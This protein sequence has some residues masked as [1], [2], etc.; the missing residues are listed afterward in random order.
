MQAAAAAVQQG[1][2]ECMGTASTN[3]CEL[4]DILRLKS[5]KHIR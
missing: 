2:S 3:E 1:I 5:A 4:S